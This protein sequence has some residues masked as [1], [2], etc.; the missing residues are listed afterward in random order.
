[1][2]QLKTRSSLFLSLRPVLLHRL[3]RWD[4]QPALVLY[5][6]LQY[7][8]KAKNTRHPVSISSIV[9]LLLL[10]VL[11]LLQQKLLLK[12]ILVHTER[13][14]EQEPPQSEDSREYG[15]KRKAEFCKEDYCSKKKK[16]KKS[17]QT[18]C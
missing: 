13:E 14:N 16:K 12:M 9:F 10:L 7:K 3:R 8:G 5:S 2:M 1:M 6:S 11:F 17:S 18:N 4:A 15:V